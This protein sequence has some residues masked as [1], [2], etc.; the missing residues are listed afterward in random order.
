MNFTSKLGYT[1]IILYSNKH[2]GTFISFSVFKRKTK[3]LF[4][5]EN[6]NAKEMGN[7]KLYF[8][9][10]PQLC[11]LVH[12]SI[13][14]IYPCQLLLKNTLPEMAC[15]ASILSSFCCPLKNHFYHEA[16]RKLPSDNGWVESQQGLFIFN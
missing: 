15:K 16:Y 4:M 5:A 1:L 7:A 12:L 6:I 2:T 3:Y 8:T 11:F 9:K 13:L 14:C 10:Q